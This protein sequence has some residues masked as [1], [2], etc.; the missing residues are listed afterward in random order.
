FALGGRLGDVVR[1][2]THSVTHHLCQD[3][4]AAP[5]RELQFLQDQDSRAF[6]DDES[7][8]VLVPGAAGFFRRIVAGGKRAHR[9]ETTY[10][11]RSDGGLRAPGDHGVRVAALDDL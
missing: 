4:G 10:A 3:P 9:G 1:V 8:A 7:I 5:A 6:A 2:G 11:H